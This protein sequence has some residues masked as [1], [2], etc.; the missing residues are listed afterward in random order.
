MANDQLT[1]T[2]PKFPKT[3]FPSEQQCPK[4]YLP[5][6]SKKKL[7]DHESLWAISEITLFLCAYYSKFQISG[8]IET[9]ALNVT[10][11]NDRLAETASSNIDDDK[12]MLKRALENLSSLEKDYEN[13]NNKS[14]NTFNSSL[15]AA[16]FIVAFMLIFILRTKCH[17]QPSKQKKHII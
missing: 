17:S 7:A 12:K 11:L 4:C 16:I 10:Q 6:S 9:A 1:E 13:N 8:I 2:D 14:G 15:M 5:N 3:P